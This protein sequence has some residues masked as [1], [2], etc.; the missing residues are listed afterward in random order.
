M[1]N[2]FTDF[3]LCSNVNSICLNEDNQ[4]L[5]RIGKNPGDHKRLKHIDI[6]YHFVREKINENVVTVNYVRSSDQ[7]A[8][9]FTKCLNQELLSKFRGQLLSEVKEEMSTYETDITLRGHVGNNN[10]MSVGNIVSSNGT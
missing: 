3:K 2:I 10:E 9:M 5:I 4:S 7:I 8:D 6:K 1:R